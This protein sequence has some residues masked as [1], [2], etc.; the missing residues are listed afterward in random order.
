M[1][2]NKGGRPWSGDVVTCH[3]KIRRR[4]NWAGAPAFIT[5]SWEC[6]TSHRVNA[7]AD[8]VDSAGSRCM[9]LH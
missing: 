9:G 6:H 4:K 3:G 1:V 8:Q 2:G 7:S 5:E